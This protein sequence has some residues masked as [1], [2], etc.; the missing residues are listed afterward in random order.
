MYEQHSHWKG[1]AFGGRKSIE[2]MLRDLG[3]KS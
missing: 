2:K 3:D 1:V